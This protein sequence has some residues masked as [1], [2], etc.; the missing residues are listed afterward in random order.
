L[1]V[2]FRYHKI[3]RKERSEKK[4]SKLSLTL[5]SCFLISS[6][7]WA[8][9]EAR[10]IHVT[11][12]SESE[13][14]QTANQNEINR[15]PLEKF[16]PRSSQVLNNV[17]VNS[18]CLPS[19]DDFRRD[20]VDPTKFYR[21][22]EDGLLTLMNCAPGTT[23]EGL[24]FED[25]L[26]VVKERCGFN[27]IHTTPA[28]V[29]EQLD[30][31]TLTTPM[32]ELV[33]QAYDENVEQTPLTESAYSAHVTGSFPPRSS[34]ILNN[35][36]VNSG[37]LPSRDDF[38]RDPVDPT[39]FYRCGE[40]GLLTLMTCAPGTVFE[41]LL[42]EDKLIVAKKRC[43]FDGMHTT[44]ASVV[45]QVDTTTI[46]QVTVA[47]QSVTQAYNALPLASNQIPKANFQK[48]VHPDAPVENVEQETIAPSVELEEMTTQASYAVHDIVPSMAQSSTEAYK[49]VSSGSF[50]PRSSQVL[51]NEI[52]NS[53]CL[54]SRD[55]FRRDP[56]DPTKFYRCGEDGLLTLMT[57][58]PGTIF[59]GL[60]FEDKLI[61]VKERCGFIGMHTTTPASVVVQVD[62]TTQAYASEQET[63]APMDELVD[64][65]TQAPYAVRD[66]VPRMVQLSK[67]AN[68][69]LASQIFR[70]RLLQSL[71][72][73]IVNS[74]CV[75]S[76]DD[77]RRDPL[78]PA[79]FYRCGEDGLLTLMNCAP[80]TVFEGFLFQDKL[81]VAKKRC[82]FPGV[83]T[84]PAPFVQVDTTKA[85]GVAEIP[86]IEFTDDVPHSQVEVTTTMAT[87]VG[88]GQSESRPKKVSY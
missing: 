62:T 54:P 23:F 44:P 11:P 19:R 55:D 47:P 71:R 16:P 83:V 39:K 41:G 32:V 56:L 80:G 40:D 18:G 45:E 63:V 2:N 46:E 69:P 78:D 88:Y 35:E 67:T 7:N 53:G 21:C 25:K 50:P 38:R 27:G 22:G 29:I 87:N 36:I 70:P 5:I 82:G 17:I 60:L 13:V 77:F 84:T 28:S 72:N 61:V 65:T 49:V 34:Q 20:P 4:M 86:K 37:C 33:S 8:S 9:F 12:E 6:L 85:P 58:A 66:I 52:V 31:A 24:L 14:Q 43:G 3:E 81:I 48:Q 59:E 74:G 75:P 30:T 57:C 64:S 79:K 73:E 76:R 15:M 1:I 26:L 10:S 51:N 68:K 42:F